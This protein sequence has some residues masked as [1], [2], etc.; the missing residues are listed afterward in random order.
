MTDTKLAPYVTG[1]VCRHLVALALASSM[2]LISSFAVDLLDIYYIGLLG[3]DRLTAAVG[4]GSTIAYFGASVGIAF[5]ISISVLIS[6]EMGR[7]DVVRTRSLFSSIWF[8]GFAVMC[9]VSLLLL[10]LAP[11]WVRLLQA[12]GE[13]AHFATQYLQIIAVGLPGRAFV[14]WGVFAMRL[15]GRVRLGLYAFVAAAGLNALLDP[16]FIFAFGWGIVGAALATAL[17]TVVAG[18]ILFFW[19]ARFSGW[20]MLPTFAELKRNLTDILKFYL[21]A[22]LTNL[23]TPVGTGVV[24]AVMAARYD[25]SA[26]AA[27]AVVA[28]MTPLL[29]GFLMSLSGSV[30][31]VV[32]QNFGAGHYDRVRKAL[33]RSVQIVACYTLPVGLIVFLAQG[34]LVDAFGLSGE[35]A[36]V[37]RFFATYL[38]FLNGLAG[39][40]FVSNAIFNNLGYPGVSTASNLLRDALLMFPLT[41]LAADWIGAPGVLLGQQMATLSVAAVS[42]WL[43]WTLTGRLVQGKVM[44]KRILWLKL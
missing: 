5:G 1:S 29:F 21:P 7:G 18:A 37:F 33:W 8:F 32:G 27:A 25:E 22:L 34:W 42:L 6:R 24:L 10:L 36:H 2:G 12:E 19:V 28:K 17:S 14:M 16:I 30:S 13:T 20:L 35:G 43:A 23:S 4:F 39:F 11:I 31:P 38:V 9:L 3:D 41:W 26:E 15:Q 44:P 40:M